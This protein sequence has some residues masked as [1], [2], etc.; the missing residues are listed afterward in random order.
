MVEHMQGPGF[1]SQPWKHTNKMLKYDFHV[2][3]WS[4]NQPHAFLLYKELKKNLT[5]VFVETE[6]SL[7]NLPGLE[8]AV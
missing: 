8:P 4:K 2:G 7:Y 1:Y 3:S 5:F 6:A